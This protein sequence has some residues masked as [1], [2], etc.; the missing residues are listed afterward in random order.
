MAT[1]LRSHC[2]P[3]SFPVFSS[4]VFLLPLLFLLLIFSLWLFSLL[5]TPSLCLHIALLSRFPQ[6]PLS[7]LPLFSF[8]LIFMNFAVIFCRLATD[9]QQLTHLHTQ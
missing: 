6:W 4:L 9:L 3:R 5:A 2:L 1:L 8:E 7:F